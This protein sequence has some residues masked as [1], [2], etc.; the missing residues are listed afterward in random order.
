MRLKAVIAVETSLLGRP[1]LG[2]SVPDREAIDLVS[3]WI[4][5]LGQREVARR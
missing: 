4:D 3:A 1:P 2:T 5:G